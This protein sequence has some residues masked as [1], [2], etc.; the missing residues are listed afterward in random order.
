[1][2]LTVF[3]LF[4][5]TLNVTR[6][7]QSHIRPM[8]RTKALRDFTRTKQ[9]VFSCNRVTAGRCVDAVLY[10]AVWCRCGSTPICWCWNHTFKLQQ[11][12][13]GCCT[14][15][16]NLLG[17]CSEMDDLVFFRLPKIVFYLLFVLCYKLKG[18]IKILM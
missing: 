18:T 8:L 17:Y 14:F 15:F 13:K 4:F 12:S 9:R 16:N 3:H 2:L 5:T 10:S 1:M 7:I 11:T 6:R